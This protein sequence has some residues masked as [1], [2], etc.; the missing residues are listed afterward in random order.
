MNIVII[1]GSARSHS[2]TRRVALHLHE[3]LSANHHADLIDL[4]KEVLPPVETVFSSEEKTP[5]EY[6]GL[7]K[8]VF[9][10][11]AFIFVSPEYNGGYSPAMKNLLDHFPKTAY[12]RKAVGI[13]TASDGL[14][15]GM[16]AAMQLQQLVCALFAVPCPQMLVTPQADKKF[17]ENGMLVDEAFTRNIDNFLT[18]YLWLA[19]SL[20]RGRQA[21]SA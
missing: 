17:E 14:F 19:G 11:D 20:F 2:M 9:E 5:A 16:R 7:R 15:G 3:R 6:L 8:K 12:A 18:E 10:A 13:V 21:T 4:R 1:S